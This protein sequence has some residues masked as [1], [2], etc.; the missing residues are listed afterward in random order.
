MRSRDR[1]R[2]RPFFSKQKLKNETNLHQWST[3]WFAVHSLFFIHP[4]VLAAFFVCFFIQPTV[5]CSSQ[6]HLEGSNTTSQLNQLNRAYPSLEVVLAI[7]SFR[8]CEFYSLRS[9][10][11]IKFSWQGK[12]RGLVG[13]SSHFLKLRFSPEN[14]LLGPL[15]WEGKWDKWP[16]SPV[17]WFQRQ[18][19]RFLCP[20]LVHGHCQRKAFDQSIFPGKT[21]E[22]VKRILQSGIGVWKWL[23]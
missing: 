11:Q 19:A 16:T 21:V 18:L 8:I 6:L 12:V 3:Y 13:S 2:K 5:S 4:T 9:I 17:S 7:L 10:L 22:Y 20:Q 1:F 15:V 14:Y 23:G